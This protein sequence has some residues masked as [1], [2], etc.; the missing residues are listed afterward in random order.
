MSSTINIT[1][2]GS[3][4][5]GKSCLVNRFVTD[6]FVTDYD[7]TIEDTWIK[8]VTC[9]SIVSK[10][11]ILDTAGQ[12]IFKD[13]CF[14]NWVA[15]A[16]AFILVY[17]ITRVETFNELSNVH[18]QILQHKDC[19]ANSYPMI[20]VGN[21]KDLESS[22]MVQTAQGEAKAKEWNCKFLESSA[23]TKENVDEMVHSCIREV[24]KQKEQMEKKSGR[25]KTSGSKCT[26][27]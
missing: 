25:K 6:D 11:E 16:D 21:K 14:Q 23:K 20:V 13:S 1:I 7:P 5:V 17:D 26:I 9:D 2:L 18:T 10:V 24:R 15:D 12:E 27:L 19:D 3:V 22:R 8:H 4:S